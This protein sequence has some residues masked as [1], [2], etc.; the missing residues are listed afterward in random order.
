MSCEH[1]NRCS[2][3]CCKRFYLPFSPDQLKTMAETGD[4]PHN[5][6]EIVFVADMV[7]P[8]EAAKDAKEG[9]DGGPPPQTGH[10]YTCRHHDAATGNC[11][12]YETRPRVCRD[13]PFYGA[14]YRNRCR[15]KTCTWE[16]ARNPPV[17]MDRQSLIRKLPRSLEPCNK[18][19]EV[20]QA[21]C[22]GQVA[23]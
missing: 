2:G 8:I 10:Y 22:S 9:V 19:L 1:N 17:A 7:I 12:T 21:D 20:T 11:T 6:E 14:G 23:V 16:E 13:F 18:A 3:D 15:Y 5:K 4:H